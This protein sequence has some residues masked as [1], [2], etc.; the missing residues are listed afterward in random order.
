[1][2]VSIAMWGQENIVWSGAKTAYVV[3]MGKQKWNLKT[4]K[5]M[6]WLQETGVADAIKDGWASRVLSF[7]WVFALCTLRFYF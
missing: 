7:L 2:I 3:T 1:M 5:Q 6:M 4:N